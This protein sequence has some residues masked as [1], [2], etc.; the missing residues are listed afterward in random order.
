[1]KDEDAVLE[2]ILELSGNCLDAKL[3]KRCPFAKKC[4]PGFIK[5]PRMRPSREERLHMA[6]DYVARKS[7]FGDDEVFED[8]E[9]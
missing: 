8:T 2:Q 9:I 1:M 3:C 6:L 5:A 4:L 7:L